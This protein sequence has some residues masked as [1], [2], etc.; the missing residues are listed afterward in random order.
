MD[1]PIAR[2]IITGLLAEARMIRL[3]VAAAALG[4]AVTNPALAQSA[5]AVAADSPDMKAIFDADQAARTSDTAIDWSKVSVEDAERRRQTKG[6]LDAGML[7]TADDYLNAAF[8]FQHGDSPSDY[9][10]AHTLAI[11][12]VSKG[13]TRG[14]WI[15]SASLDRYL[16]AIGQK[17]IYGTQYKLP[18]GAPVTQEPYDKAL[19]SDALRTT[20][21]VPTLS[22]QEKE[23]EEWEV[24]R[25]KTKK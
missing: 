2:C 21:R 14:L 8:I 12:S 17:Q 7:S 25:A 1:K 24:E 15:A 18:E 20:L 3:M 5:A 13:Q 4:P 19:I 16:Q 10:L 9:L 11:V 6:L 22:E 23:R